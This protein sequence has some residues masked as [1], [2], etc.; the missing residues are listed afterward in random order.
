[1][2]TPLQITFTYIISIWCWRLI[3]YRI[4]NYGCQVSGFDPQ[5]QGFDLSHPVS[6]SSTAIPCCSPSNIGPALVRGRNWN[7]IFA[8]IFHE[9][10]HNEWGTPTMQTRA[11]WRLYLRSCP[12]KLMVIFS[13]RISAVCCQDDSG[14]SSSQRRMHISE[15]LRCSDLQEQWDLQ[16]V[17]L[18]PHFIRCL[19]VA[20]GSWRIPCRDLH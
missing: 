18:H 6:R 15:Q 20:G 8:H 7:W 5:F 17:F 4:D 3:M 9:S 10:F 2:D 1:M 13:L 12:T 16:L 14:I 11:R 19:I